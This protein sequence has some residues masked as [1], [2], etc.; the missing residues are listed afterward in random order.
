[1]RLGY[2]VACVA[3]LFASAAHAEGGCPA[4]QYPIGGQGAVGC[5]PMPQQ[6]QQQQQ[7]PR[8]SGEWIKTWGAISIGVKGSEP[9]YGVPVGMRTK[10][11][12]EQEALAR[13]AKL[14]AEHC[15]VVLTYQN[16]CAA[17]GEPKTDG[18]PNPDGYVQFIGQPDKESA[19]SE[20]LRTCTARNPTMQCEVI[21]A[22]CTE[23]IFR[24]F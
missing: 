13:C 4:G 7:A 8:P 10:A 9:Y 21:Y 15:K 6:Q 16:Q 11:E 12:A 14:G 5:A 22:A 2:V 3:M 24:K 23:P 18:K 19:S 20:A 17:I 1:M